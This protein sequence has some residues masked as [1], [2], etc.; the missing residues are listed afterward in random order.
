MLLNV[1]TE[2]SVSDY[3]CQAFDP[4]STS[5]FRRSVAIVGAS[6]VTSKFNGDSDTDTYASELTDEDE[7][8]ANEVNTGEIIVSDVPGCLEV[9]TGD[10]FQPEPSTNSVG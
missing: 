2:I 6:R 8:D 5:D 1:N 10:S 4:I 7:G 3:D 9:R